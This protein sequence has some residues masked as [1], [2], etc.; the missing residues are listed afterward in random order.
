MVIL[1]WPWQA[2][3]WRVKAAPPLLSSAETL[4]EWR[5]HYAELFREPSPFN[6]VM[7]LTICARD[8]LHA[9]GP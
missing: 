5:Q 6:N 1:I 2:N 4:V 9:Y 7:Q 3:R 8:A